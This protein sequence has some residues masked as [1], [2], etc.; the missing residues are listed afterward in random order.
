MSVGSSSREQEMGGW[1]DEG[2]VG[3]WRVSDERYYCL[4][5]GSWGGLIE[6][7]RMKMQK[8]QQRIPRG[9][10]LGEWEVLASCL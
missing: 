1:L 6:G 2:Q 5:I 7:K 10:S 3:S 9:Q 8:R 4:F